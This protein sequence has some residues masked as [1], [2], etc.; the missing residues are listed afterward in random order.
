MGV[1]LGLI[2]VS[3]GI[4][5]IGDIFRGFGTST[6]ATVGRT[7]IRVDTF[8]QLYQDRLQQLGRQ[9][10]RPIL[11]DQA[12]ALGL[13]RQVL[14]EVIAETALDDRARAMRLN[15]SDAE[16]AR[17]VTINPGFKGINGQF[18]RNRFEQGLRN[19]G[20]TEARFLSEQRKIALRQQ[21]LGTVS[22]EPPVPKT[23]LEAFNRFQNEERTIEY[24]SLGPTQ[25]GT[26][27]EPTPEVL[28]KY[29]EERKA[30]FRAPEY[31]KITVVVLTPQD[32][33]SRIEVPEADLKKAYADRKARYETP[34]R[35][36]LKQIVF[37]NIDEAKAAAD[38]LAR[39]TTFEALAAERGLKET[40]IDLG[41]VAKSA[42]VDRDVA[43]AAFALQ[44]GAVSA[45]IQGR[46][47]IA[48]VKVDA[49]E[50]GKTR[51]FEDV[52][53]E[54]KRDM[55]N[56]RAKNEITNVQ[57]KIEDERLGGAT[58][59]DAA[60]KFNLKPRVIE[61]IERDGKDAQ[62]NP[63]A[64]LPQNVDVLNAAFSAEVHGENEPLRVPGNG[65]YV[66]FDVD[67]ITPARDRPLAEVKDQVVARW[68][69]DEIATRLKAKAAE[70]LDK[71]KGGTSFADAAA[72]DKLKIEWRPGIKRSGPPTGLTPAA[73]TEVFKTPQDS[74]GSVEAN[75]TERIVFRVTEI[76]VAPLDPEAADAKR[77]DEAL[78]ARVTED[79]IAQY[80]AHVQGEIG[81]SVNQTALNQAAGGAQN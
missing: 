34:E 37:P 72:A 51:P 53:G 19:I 24:V 79:L 5:G 43:D 67:A 21:L 50:A 3:F 71:I 17:Q 30:A 13:D 29:F 32:L 60:R 54:L 58:L 63:V 81:V 39:G 20:Y 9:F 52:V 68:R 6:V 36:H 45:P 78:R 33:A 48:I 42:V 55:Q 22:G 49:I 14:G 27:A 56:E 70:M 73:V 35:R 77:I 15:V 31:R 28:A 40:D 66:W 7:E 41:T 74:V 38:R 2:A 76:K 46:F 25:A 64:D 65:G 23:A 47:G 12:K 11:P 1:V 80:L 4:W 16:V 44:T 62:G 69:D 59:A 61:A 10:N 75:P 26:L 57:E 18:D 8:R